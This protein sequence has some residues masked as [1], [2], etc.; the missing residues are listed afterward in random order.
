MKKIV[1]AVV[2]LSSVGFVVALRAQGGA[3]PGAQAAPAAAPGTP[4]AA[5]AYWAGNRSEC[6]NC[7]GTNGE[8]GFGPDLAGRGLNAD[9]F[10]RAV[11]QP[12]G[13]MPAYIDSQVSELDIAGLTAY[14]ASMPKTAQVGPWVTPVPQNAPAPQLALIS[15][16]GT[17]RCWFR[18]LAKK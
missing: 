13:V 15:P 4:E 11:R 6:R 2:L 9:E 16:I 3:A 18:F 5:R 8:G 10:R 7:H 17:F 1:L 14:F 12:W